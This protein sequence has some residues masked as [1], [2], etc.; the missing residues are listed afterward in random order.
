MK[1]EVAEF[2]TFPAGNVMPMLAMP[3]TGSAAV[4]RSPMM[5]GGVEKPVVNAAIKLTNVTS[6]GPTLAV[7]GILDR[8]RTAR[9]ADVDA[10]VTGPGDGRR[11][12]C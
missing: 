6:K 10:I 5:T 4:V 12:P 8:G 9:V 11:T 1:P 3:D 7:A 2:A